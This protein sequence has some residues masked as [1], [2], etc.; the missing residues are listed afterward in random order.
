MG[1]FD[2]SWNPINEIGHQIRKAVVTVLDPID[3]C[4]GLTQ[5]DMR[6]RELEREIRKSNKKNK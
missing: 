5:Q 6:E 1:L 3:M 4:Q 2:R